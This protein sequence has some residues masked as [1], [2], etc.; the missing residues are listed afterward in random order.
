MKTI[1]GKSVDEIVSKLNKEQKKIADSLR[2]IAAGAV[3]EAIE[4]VKWGNIVYELNEKNLAW[5]IF[6]QNHVD[7]GFFRGAELQSEILEG[8]GKSMRHIKIIDADTIPS[9]EITGLLKKASELE[10]E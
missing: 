2:S 9:E 4:T 1:K 8:T 3:P 6:Y 10:K 7:F 5:L